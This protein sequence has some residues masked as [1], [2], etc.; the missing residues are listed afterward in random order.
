MTNRVGP[1]SLA[2]S[3]VA[4][5]AMLAETVYAVSHYLLR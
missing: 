3:I 1:F 4:L 5:I 2:F